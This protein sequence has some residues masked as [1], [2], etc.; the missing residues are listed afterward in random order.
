M[1]KNNANILVTLKPNFFDTKIY[2]ESSNGASYQ[3]FLLDDDISVGSTSSF[4]YDPFESG[5]RST[6]QLN[7]DWSNLSEH[8]FFN[9]AR[10]KTNEA[11]KTI[12]NK[13]PFDGTKK[14]YENFIDSLSGY[15]R[16]ILNQFPYNFGYFFSN[17]SG[18]ITTKD[19]SGVS[20]L[21]IST[22]KSG[23]SVLNPTGSVSLSIE[24]WI[25]LPTGSNSN[26]I[27]LQ[28]LSGSHG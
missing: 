20:D 8:V 5:I 22:N 15:Q 12:I 16:Y 4:R 14:D 1:S 19:Y 27:I 28:K 6:Q 26:E 21:E 11:F 17:G 13:F 3:Q 24:N 25:F 2:D 7:V 18:F 9:S 23:I 10:V